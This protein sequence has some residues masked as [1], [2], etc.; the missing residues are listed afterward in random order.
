[1]ME[2]LASWLRRVETDSRPYHIDLVGRKAIAGA[3]KV[4]THYLSW[5]S[6][7]EKAS[8]APLQRHPH[9]RTHAS[10]NAGHTE[11]AFASAFAQ[12]RRSTVANTTSSRG[13]G[14][15]LSA[16]RP[17]EP[18]S[19]GKV[20][21]AWLQPPGCRRI[22][23]VHGGQGCTICRWRHRSDR[24]RRPRGRFGR[25]F[26]LISLAARIRAIV[27]LHSSGGPL[28]TSHRDAPPDVA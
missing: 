14:D 18:E 22:S 8:G 16:R 5:R 23:A 20:R 28:G 7:T 21:T 13:R 24:E 26:F 1:M 19:R 10:G 3:S 25:S 27:V 11:R 12:E 17:N 4:A 15:R 9:P 6:R 2:E